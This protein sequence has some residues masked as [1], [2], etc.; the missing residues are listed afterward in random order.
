MPP[1]IKIVNRGIRVNLPGMWIAGI[2]CVEPVAAAGGTG[3]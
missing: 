1:L 3:D 2:V